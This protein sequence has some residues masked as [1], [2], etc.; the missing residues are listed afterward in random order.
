MDICCSFE[1]LCPHTS[2]RIASISALGTSCSELA[3][4]VLASCLNCVLCASEFD[5][6][7]ET[8]QA[9]QAYVPQSTKL[10]NPYFS[11]AVIAATG[12]FRGQA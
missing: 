3:G 5:Y 10:V 8:N 2:P 1:K 7:Y 12:R 9:S 6:G 4:R 11:G